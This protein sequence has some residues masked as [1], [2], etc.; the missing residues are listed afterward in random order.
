VAI[1]AIFDLEAKM[2]SNLYNNNPSRFLMPALLT[3]D[4]FFAIL[5]HLVQQILQ[6]MCFKAAVLAILNLTHKRK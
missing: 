3:F 1:V 5:A 6:F 2:V 4:T